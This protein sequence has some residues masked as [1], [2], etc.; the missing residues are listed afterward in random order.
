MS[1]ARH[2]GKL[3]QTN[4]RLRV[5]I[6]PKLKDFRN[7]VFYIWQELGLPAPTL[8][9]YDIALFLHHG[10]RRRMVQAFRGVGKSW[11]TAA[12]VIWRLLLN[13]NERV[14]VVSAS[15]ERADAFSI[16]VKRLIEQ[17]DFLRRLA[18]DPSK[19][20]RDSN[21]T[22]DVSGSDPHQAP[23]VK[24]VGI[25][26]QITGSRASIIVAD[27]IET[28]KNSLTILQRERLGELVKEFD[29]VLLPDGEVI[30]LGTPQCEESIYTKLP[31]RGYAVRIWPARRP[32]AAWLEHYSP[33]LTPWL[34]GAIQAVPE[35][36]PLD[37]QR[38]TSDDLDQRELSYG[39]TGFA[40]QFML[41]SRLSDALKYPL[42]L[43]DLIVMNVA[44]MVPLKV[45][46]GGGVKEHAVELPS[47]GL[48]GDRMFRPSWTHK[49]YCEFTGSVMFIDPSGRGADETSYAVVKI[50]NSMLYLTACGGFRDG[51]SDE[52]LD[53]L[54]DIAKTQGVNHVLV[55]PNFGDGMFTK[56]FQP[57]LLAV[58]K[59]LLEESERATGQKEM[60]IVN[61]LEPVLNQHRLV[62]CESVVKADFAVEDPNYQLLY[63]MTRLTKEKKALAHDD[64][65]EAVA[66]AVAY[67]IE[68]LARSTT[69]AADMTRDR[70][71][72]EELKKF[73]Q[74][75]IDPMQRQRRS[76]GP[77]ALRG[78][79]S[80]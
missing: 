53:K 64:R 62:I 57:H 78:A 24:S 43:Q 58:H 38:F 69:K 75:I 19:G 11:L 21:I 74:Q 16:F 70:L 1:Q 47:V 13:P 80:M 26:G 25:T 23:S 59:C 41:D 45:V 4:A 30:Y 32:D 40:L 65:I 48:K 61:I 6:D 27:D 79:Y 33:F 12:Y 39:R 56:L 49:D 44:D 9:Q 36:F 55:E 52:V 7:F 77:R 71:Q 20:H 46:W 54:A 15:K 28:P 2:P 29:A 76:R 42:K 72:K 68:Q 66:G 18:P 50:A 31:E 63:Q 73:K 51:Y 5:A 67:F 17:V 8:A 34:D 3:S 35:G 37:S 22:F 60:R 14:M 10:P